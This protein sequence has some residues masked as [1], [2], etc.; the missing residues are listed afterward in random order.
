MKTIRQ[1]ELV[2]NSKGITKLRIVE[3]KGINYYSLVEFNQK[4]FK[5]ELIAGTF[6]DI[7]T[8]KGIVNDDNGIAETVKEALNEMEVA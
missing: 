2:R 5:Y 3:E 8:L 4:A 1:I 6:E 7:N